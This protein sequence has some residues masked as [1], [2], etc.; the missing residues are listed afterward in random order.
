MCVAV[1][2][3]IINDVNVDLAACIPKQAFKSRSPSTTKPKPETL[4]NVTF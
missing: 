3:D 4:L 2:K 1:E